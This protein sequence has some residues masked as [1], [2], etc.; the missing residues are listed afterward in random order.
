[1]TVPFP[2][3]PYFPST[4]TPPT[5]VRRPS[6]IGPPLGFPAVASPKSHIASP[7]TSPA[8][9]GPAGSLPE[10]QQPGSSADTFQQ[11]P[12]AAAAAPPAAPTKRFGIVYTRRHKDGT[13]PAPALFDAPAPP[14]S[15][16]APPPGPPSPLP[17][18]AIPVPPV[19]N[20]HA[21]RT[22][23]K[24]GIRMPAVFQTAE[25]SLVPRTYRAALADPN[26]RVTMEA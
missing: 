8:G 6:T 21:M 24:S 7:A 22:R 4:G 16:T 11:P 10:L 2:P 20:Q 15:L 9:L 5:P 19:Q 13:A 14:A 18:G 26:W 12:A 23:G 1:V 3:S 25:L 17:A